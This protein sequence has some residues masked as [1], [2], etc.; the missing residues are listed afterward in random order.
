MST[1]DISMQLFELV[2]HFNRQSR[3]YTSLED[4]HETAALLKKDIGRIISEC[5]TGNSNDFDKKFVS[6]I[7]SYDCM[8]MEDIAFASFTNQEVIHAMARQGFQTLSEYH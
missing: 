3:D 1:S 4:D 2:K 7:R 8:K 5:L 6:L